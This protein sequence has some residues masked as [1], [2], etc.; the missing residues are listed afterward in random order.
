MDLIAV[1]DEQYRRSLF[2]ETGTRMNLAPGLVE[3]DF[4]VCWTV[5]RLFDMPLLRNHL[6]FKGGTTLS[7]VYKI[8][9]RFSEDIDLTIE[10]AV[11]GFGGENDPEAATSNK[12]REKMIQA[13]GEACSSYVRND[14]RETFARACREVLGEHDSWNVAVDDRDEDGQT[15]LFHYPPAVMIDSST[16]YVEPAVR[17]EFGSRGEQWPTE[18]ISV[19][20]Y[21]A[22]QFPEVFEK[23]GAE[24]TALTAERTFWEKATILH[25][26]ANRPEVKPMPERCSRHYYDLTMLADSQVKAKALEEISLLE[27]VVHHKKHFFRCGWAEYD[28]AKPGTLT[29]LPPEDRLKSLGDDYRRMQ[30]MMFGDAPDFDQILETLEKLQ[31]EINSHAN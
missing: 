1:K 13:M 11:F 7:K 6:V 29:L 19:Q 14:I 12:K 17:L 10:R 31:N 3:K 16:A 21:A 5:K 15:L 30:V 27:S 20:P 28:T 26:E 22:E 18:H 4:W 8:I 2:E 25:Q 23:P 24:V 9:Q